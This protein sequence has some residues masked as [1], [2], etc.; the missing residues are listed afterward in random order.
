MTFSD[1]NG[2]RL[3]LKAPKKIA[4][5]DILIFYFYLLKKGLIFHV[6]SHLKHQVLFS[7]KNTEKVYMN[8]VRCSRDW[9]CKG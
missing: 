2:N 6:N 7:R 9:R 1:H 8:V 3:T 4:A 5:D